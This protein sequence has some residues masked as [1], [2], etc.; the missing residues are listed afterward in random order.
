MITHIQFYKGYATKLANIGNKRFE[1]TKG[2]NVLFGPNGCGKST[3]LKTAAAYCAIPNAGWSMHSDAKQFAYQGVEYFPHNYATFAPGNCVADVGW[4]G[5]PTLFNAGDIGASDSW[6]FQN[7]GQNKDNVF[8]EQEQ[9]LAMINNPSSG[10]YRAYQINK[11]LNALKRNK[12]TDLLPNSSIP[13]DD[14]NIIANEVQYIS[15]LPRTGPNTILFDEP[16]R[17]LSLPKQLAFFNALSQFNEYQII[18]STHSPLILFQE[19][20]NIIDVESG[21]TQ[22]CVQILVNLFS[23][24]S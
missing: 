6:F 15:S 12:P 9:M 20:I 19:N 4:D 11:I 23:N 18:I 16:E 7:A 5:T 24:I 8:S 14:M 2:I 21:Y 13:Q 1:F 3:I 22:E 17:S 10:E